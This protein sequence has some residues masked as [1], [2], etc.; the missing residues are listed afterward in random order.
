MINVSADVTVPKGFEWLLAYLTTSFIHKVCRSSSAEW[1]NDCERWIVKD[2][3]ESRRGLRVE[4]WDQDLSNTKQECRP[5]RK[6]IMPVFF[7][8]NWRFSEGV[9]R[10]LTASDACFLSG[11]A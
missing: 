5:L 8:E 9:G 4:I 7:L 6:D 11:S 10:N 3:Q 1:R 2:V